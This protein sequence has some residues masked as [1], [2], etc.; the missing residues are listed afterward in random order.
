MHSNLLGLSLFDSGSEL[1][2]N[3]YWTDGEAPQKS[4]MC[5]ESF[6]RI[7]GAGGP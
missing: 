3:K 4:Q 7:I 6:I 5:V 1:C 2:V